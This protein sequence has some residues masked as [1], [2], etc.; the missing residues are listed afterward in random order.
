M[1][2]KKRLDCMSWKS[3]YLSL[4]NSQAGVVEHPRCVKRKLEQGSEDD[5]HEHESSFTLYGNQCEWDNIVSSNFVASEETENDS[6]DESDFQ[7]DENLPSISRPSTPLPSYSLPSKAEYDGPLLVSPPEVK[8]YWKISFVDGSRRQHSLYP[9]L[10][11]PQV[12]LS[13]STCPLS[14]ILW[15]A[16]RSCM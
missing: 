10:Q 3:S 14:S 12:P 7:E 9:E 1:G 8:A 11:Y 4:T 16:T 15:D 13:S 6:D 5:M 2:G